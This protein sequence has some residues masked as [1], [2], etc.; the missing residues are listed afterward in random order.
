M[1]YHDLPVAV[2]D[3]NQFVLLFENLIENAIKYRGAEPPDIEIWGEESDTAHVLS[4]RDNGPGIEE[5]YAALVFEPFK[6]LHSKS[7][8]GIGLGLS[9]CRKIAAG[10]DG[11]IWVES[12]GQHGSVFKVSI[13]F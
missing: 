3:E 6:R 1:R 12:D 2:V 13:P 11:E 7:I 10:H 9:I 5:Q 4:V 8:P